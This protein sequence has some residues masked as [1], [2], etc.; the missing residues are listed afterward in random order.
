MGVF[1]LRA[2]ASARVVSDG[3]RCE[4]TGFFTLRVSGLESAGDMQQSPGGIQQRQEILAVM[5]EL[6]QHGDFASVGMA[7]TSADLSV[8]TFLGLQPESVA[9]DA[10]GYS[11]TLGHGWRRE[12]ASASPNIFASAAEGRGRQ[13]RVAQVMLTLSG[14]LLTLTKDGVE[15]WRWEDVPKGWAFAV[16]GSEDTIWEIAWTQRWRQPS[17]V[18]LR[19]G[20]TDSPSAQRYAS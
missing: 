15:L 8:G 11:Y 4:G 9:L 1:E 19:S 10:A 20:H 16:G 3:S 14:R 7:S 2:E 5:L 18:P 12:G 17:T 13:G 6:V